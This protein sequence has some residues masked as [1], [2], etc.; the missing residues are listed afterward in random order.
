VSGMSC[1]DASDQRS[2]HIKGNEIPRLFHTHSHPIPETALNTKEISTFPYPASCL[3]QRPAALDFKSGT[4]LGHVC[5]KLFSLIVMPL[6]FEAHGTP[7]VT[8]AMVSAFVQ[9]RRCDPCSISSDSN[10]PWRA[11][12]GRETLCACGE[13]VPSPPEHPSRAACRAAKRLRVCVQCASDGRGKRWL[14]NPDP[15]KA[16]KRYVRNGLCVAPACAR[17]AVKTHEISSFSCLSLPASA[18]PGA[19]PAWA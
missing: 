12:P 16:A 13:I 1:P 4:V 19:K 2:L 9:G 18:S 11:A 8:C 17:N 7:N 3:D 10:C 6:A 14:T 5:Q 15:L